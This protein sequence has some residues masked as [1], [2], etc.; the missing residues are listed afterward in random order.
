[1]G[2]AWAL[3]R[4]H[5]RH[6]V[7]IAFIMYV[8]IAILT[9]VLILLLGNLGA[10]A[11][12]FVGV[13]AVFWLQ[14]ALVLAV[15]DIRDGRA[16]LTIRQT[17]EGVRR[18]INTLSLL[19]FFFVLMF[20]IA[21]VL[22]IVGFYLFVIPGIALIFV[23][24]Y[25]FVRWILAV[26]VIML[27]ERGVFGGLDRSGELVRGHFWKVLWVILLTLLVLIG[28]GIAISAVL[29]PLPNGVQGLVAQ[30]V[31]S[32]LTAPFAALAW[33]LMYYE[34]RGAPEP[35]LAAAA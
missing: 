34:L 2:Q 6:L 17:L 21:A 14:G 28:A 19:G 33:T 30:L 15:D 12:V 35:A 27:E 8:L 20:V 32:T 24:F 1:M 25:F 10:L 13:A 31:S 29:S 7:S 4:A 3:Y 9:L 23:F 26:P 18:R 11:A 16:D 22:I 5:F